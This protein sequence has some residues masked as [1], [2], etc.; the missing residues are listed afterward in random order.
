MST[1]G[2][3]FGQALI[4]LVSNKEKFVKGSLLSDGK[5][6]TPDGRIVPKMVLGQQL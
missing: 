4:G 3:N 6:I 2:Y 1:S 5:W